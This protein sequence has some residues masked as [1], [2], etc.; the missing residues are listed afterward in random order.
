MTDPELLFPRAAGILL[1]PTSLPGAYGIGDLGETAYRFVDWLEDAEQ[2]IWQILPLGPTSYG[3]SPYQTLS[4]FA[5][6]PNLISLDSLVEEGWL[7]PA[8][9][10]NLPYFPL[11]RVDYGRIIP[12]HDQK[13]T[14][15][16]DRFTTQGTVAQ[17]Q[18]YK[19]WSEENN[20]WLDDFTLFAALKDL[21]EGKPWVEWPQAEA[22]REPEALSAAR[23]KLARRIADHRFR[24]WI[25]HA[26]WS[27]LRDYAH[28]KGIRLIGDIPIFVAHDSS[29]VWANRERFYL[30]ETGNP[31]VVAGVPPDYFS[32]TGQRW[33]NPLYRWDVMRASG[34][35]WWISRFQ[36]V[37]ETVDIARIDHFRGFEAYW[38]IPATEKTAVKGEWMPGPGTDFF[39]VVRD[40]LG[41]LPLIAEDLG[42]I[43]EEVEALRDNYD[44]PG[45]KVLQFAWSEPDNPFLPHNHVPNCV[46]Y[47]GTHDNNT[48]LGWWAAETDDHTRWLMREYLDHEVAGSQLDAHSAR[49]GFGGPYLCRANAGY[50][51]PGCPRTHERARRRGRELD[52]ALPRGRADGP[53]PRAAGAPDLAHPP[54]GRSAGENLWGCGGRQGD[55][56]TLILILDKVNVVQVEISRDLA[57]LIIG[58]QRAVFAIYSIL[59]PIR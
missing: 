53:N 38:E 42:V 15:A 50:S 56:A 21:H 25:F 49:H 23:I 39:D 36:A 13:L 12:W 44:L 43:T 55:L 35:S 40:A 54:P 48:S 41:V 27:A 8:D 6:N 28:E 33:G 22:L 1:H 2:R 47:S 5:G 31:T 32:E 17:H 58:D 4:A 14:L 34:Y 11:D 10:A 46:V 19:T 29:D 9:L 37:L 52:L 45:M 16:Y 3:D 26:Q 20:H 30:D 57:F 51:R 59:G 24:Q 7:T 18:A